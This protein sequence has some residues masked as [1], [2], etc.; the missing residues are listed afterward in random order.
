MATFLTAGAVQSRK[1]VAEAVP[2]KAQLRSKVSLSMYTDLPDGEIAIEE[3]ERFAMDRLRG[4][5]LPLVA[6]QPERVL[7]LIAAG[8]MSWG[9]WTVPCR[10]ARPAGR[11]GSHAPCPRP[12]SSHN[13]QP[14]KRRPP[15]LCNPDMCVCAAVLKGID[16][17]K[18]KGF[19]HDQMQVQQYTCPPPAGGRRWAVRSPLHAQMQVQV[20]TQQGGST[21]T[22]ACTVE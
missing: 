14:V 11:G 15:T 10:G 7:G 6:C 12:C 8:V 2:V 9:V 21:L 18:V 22:L 1:A 19:R 16:D 13:T 17:L 3:F 4:E 5:G 20:Y